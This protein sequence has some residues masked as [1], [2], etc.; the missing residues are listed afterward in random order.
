MSNT[1]DLR[2]SFR[3]R[4]QRLAKNEPW[5][6]EVR[7]GTQSISICFRSR[8]RPKERQVSRSLITIGGE[9]ASRGGYT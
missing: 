2:E 9:L 5:S 3:T 6:L 7:L 1:F 8:Q 4:V